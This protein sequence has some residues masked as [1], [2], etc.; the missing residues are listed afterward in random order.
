MFQGTRPFAC[1]RAF[2]LFGFAAER[3]VLLPL[4][5]D[6]RVQIGMSK[7]GIDH[8]ETWERYPKAWAQRKRLNGEEDTV[9]TNEMGG[10][11]YIR[12]VL[13]SSCDVNW[14]QCS[15]EG[16]HIDGETVHKYRMTLAGGIPAICVTNKTTKEEFEAQV[17]GP[18]GPWGDFESKRHGITLPAYDITESTF[19]NLQMAADYW[20][21]LVLHGEDFRNHGLVARR[22][23]KERITAD[24]Q[25]L[26]GWLVGMTKHILCTA[27]LFCSIPDTL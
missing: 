27:N 17:D 24:V 22:T 26:L 8:H 13:N 6:Y 1:M 7:F 19:E 5:S 2:K 14:A 11:V 16:S 20:D 15:F 25:I 21:R 18:H 9:I 23:Y 4:G 3:E 10:P 12:S